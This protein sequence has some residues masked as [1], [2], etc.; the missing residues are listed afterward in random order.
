MNIMKAMAKPAP[1]L[2]ILLNFDSTAPEQEF[3]IYS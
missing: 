2:Q 1:A 3:R